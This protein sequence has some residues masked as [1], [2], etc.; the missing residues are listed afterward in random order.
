M[1]HARRHGYPVPRVLEVTANALVLERIE[2]PTMADQMRRRISRLHRNASL[3]ARLHQQLHEIDAPVNLPA[4]S[5]GDRLLH[6]DLHAANVILAPTGPVVVD[7]T[8]ARRGDPAFDVALTW[9]IGATSGGR[10]RLSQS[11]LRRFMSH[12]D[13][14]ELLDA[15]P[16][17]AE[18][19]LADSNVTDSERQAIRDLVRNAGV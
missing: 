13:R 2:G 5:P 6:L 3:L 1:R 17:A 11:F 15:L 16:A 9:V 4:V 19:R 8:N 18:W 10:G 7:W 12:F 14:R